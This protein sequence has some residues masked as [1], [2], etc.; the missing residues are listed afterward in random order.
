LEPLMH[1]YFNPAPL[2]LNS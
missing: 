2:F 1:M